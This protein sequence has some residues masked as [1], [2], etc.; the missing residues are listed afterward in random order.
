MN[1][2]NLQ[3]M[4]LNPFLSQIADGVNESPAF[5]LTRIVLQYY[6]DLYAKHNGLVKLLINK[7][8]ITKEDLEIQ[9]IDFYENDKAWT[10]I[11]VEGVEEQEIPVPGGQNIVITKNLV[12]KL[13]H[14]LASSEEITPDTIKLL[15]KEANINIMKLLTP[16]KIPNPPS[17]GGIPPQF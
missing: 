15:F 5:I 13:M 4:L 9:E 10:D 12:H 8:I 7:G 17:P 16:P 14:I 2:N 6:R 11:F 1:N 3:D